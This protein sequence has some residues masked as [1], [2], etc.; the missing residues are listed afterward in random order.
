MGQLIQLARDDA[1]TPHEV[2]HEHDHVAIRTDAVYVV[3][4]SIDETLAAVRIAC[5]LAQALSVPLTLVHTRTV[6]YV[7]PVDAPNG[8]SPVQTDAFVNRI[9]DVGRQAGVDVRVRIYLCREVQ[10]V[11]P[12]AFK[13]HSLIV[14]AGQRSWWPTRTE[15]WRRALEAAGHFVLFVD[16]AEHESRERNGA[17]GPHERAARAGRRA[18]AT[19]KERSDA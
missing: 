10:Q 2:T 6:P 11:V 17:S 18:P 13:P 4:T 7:L 1:E 12:L 3:Y 14:I 15:R 9:R 5:E 16:D 8:L 19:N